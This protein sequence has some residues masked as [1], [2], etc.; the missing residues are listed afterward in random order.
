LL[1]R[2]TGWTNFAADPVV[3]EEVKDLDSYVLVGDSYGAVSSI[4]VATRQPKGLKGPVLSMSLWFRQER[5]HLAFA[6]V[7]D[8]ACTVLPRSVDGDAQPAFLSL[9]V[10]CRR[11]VCL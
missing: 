11:E 10:P 3:N 4:A 8:Q 5:A 9:R 6:Q 7:S 2:I 1:S